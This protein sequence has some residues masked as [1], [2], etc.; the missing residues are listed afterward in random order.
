MGTSASLKFLKPLAYLS[1]D[2]VRKYSNLSLELIVNQPVYTKPGL[3]YR[4][5]DAR[6]SL[7]EI[8]YL[9]EKNG[10]IIPVEVKSGSFE[11]SIEKFRKVSTRKILN[12]QDLLKHWSRLFRVLY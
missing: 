8:D 3:Y 9:F 4:G 10:E 11:K 6:N 1:L 5:R 7:A 2:F 12:S